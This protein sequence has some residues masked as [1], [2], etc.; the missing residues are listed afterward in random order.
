MKEEEIAEYNRMYD[1]KRAKL[2]QEK[3]GKV[4]LELQVEPAVAVEQGNI[5]A[6]LEDYQGEGEE[7]KPVVAVKPTPAL[8]E[9]KAA[10][11]VIKPKSS[12]ISKMKKKIIKPDIG[13]KEQ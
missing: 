1:E 11:S 8:E 13:K 5:E 7:I 4:G 9:P 2:L 12:L 3:Y 10:T 6:K